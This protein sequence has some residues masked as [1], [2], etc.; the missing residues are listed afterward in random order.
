MGLRGADS[1]SFQEAEA[2]VGARNDLCRVDLS[3]AN[4][5]SKPNTLLACE[6]T[7]I[8]GS[9]VTARGI[10]P[11]VVGGSGI[12][13]LPSPTVHYARFIICAT[14]LVLCALC[15]LA[16]D[17]HGCSNSNPADE[18]SSSPSSASQTAPKAEE[19]S[20]VPLPDAPAPVA[21]VSEAQT[22]LHLPYNK[23]TLTF[24]QNQGQAES[25]MRFFPDHTGYDRWTINTNAVLGQDAR[26][27]NFCGKGR[28]FNNSAPTKWM[29]FGPTYGHA[30]HETIHGANDLEYYG[31]H[32]PWAG[33]V[34]LR[35]GQEARAHPHITTVL[36]TVQPRF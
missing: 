19:M 11:K 5:P 10:R 22:R 23:L 30:H 6:K 17:V 8:F 16:S 27:A 32:I 26:T 24:K 14:C 12:R 1:L 34:V 9:G 33:S 35:I 4:R 25:W 2:V 31:H 13:D 3:H 21:T 28:Y 15:V 18:A 7:F 29:T 20:S 36:K